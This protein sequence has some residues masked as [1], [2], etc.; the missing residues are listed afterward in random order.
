MIME[1][2]SLNQEHVDIYKVL[3]VIRSL[4]TCRDKQVAAVATNDM[5][6]ITSV[7]YNIPTEKCNS[8]EGG[9]HPKD[10]ARHAERGLLLMPG[11]KVYITTFPCENCQMAMWS[12]GVTEV[13]VFGKQHKKDTGLLDIHILPDIVDHLISFNGKE[14]QLQVIIGELAE[15][16]T[17]IADSTRKDKKD[18]RNIVAELIDVELQ[19]RCLHRCI[20]PVYLTG[21]EQKKYNELLRRLV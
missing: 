7:S 21:M 20:G 2:D 15:L 16:I 11:D 5:G 3:E 1:W 4:S 14:K 17:A 10:C 19:L 9:K 12:S 18:N 13:Y 8:C 6:L